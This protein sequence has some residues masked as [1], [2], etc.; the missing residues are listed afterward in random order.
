MHSL[1]LAIEVTFC[2][3]PRHGIHVSSGD[4]GAG[5]IAAGGHGVSVRRTAHWDGVA[6]RRGLPLLSVGTEPTLR[7]LVIYWYNSCAFTDMLDDVWLL[8]S[9]SRLAL[10]ASYS[11]I[12]YQSMALTR[13]AGLRCNC[14]F[15]WCNIF[16]RWL[17]A[18][19]SCHSIIKWRLRVL[20]LKFT[21]MQYELH[22]FLFLS[23]RARYLY[24][25]N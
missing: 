8:L 25:V 9:S 20:C 14:H 16:L 13:D 19:E 10:S 2:W 17:Y 12:I 18:S 3:S 6:W 4:H 24:R 5:G 23:R 7:R 15:T 1:R 21:C 22:A 11:Y